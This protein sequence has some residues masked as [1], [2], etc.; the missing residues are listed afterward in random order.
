MGFILPLYKMSPQEHLERIGY[1]AMLYF[2]FQRS[3]I[4]FLGVCLIF[5]LAVLPVNYWGG[6]GMT[7]F[8]STT[9]AN[10]TD[11]SL[12][13]VHAAVT[14]LFS[15]WLY[16]FLWYLRGYALNSHDLLLERYRSVK[17]AVS[18]HSIWIRNF[19]RY[20][21]DVVVVSCCSCCL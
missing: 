7:G 10:V 8:L 9:V 13:W 12:Y 11:P 17:S 5:G 1:D 19:P 4:G 6:K 3:V 2:Y 20:V 18:V 15:I 21:V 16:I 14:V